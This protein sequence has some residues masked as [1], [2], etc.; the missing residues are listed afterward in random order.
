M[1]TP[2]IMKDQ[3]E[4]MNTIH[5]LADNRV[6]ACDENCRKKGKRNLV[7]LSLIFIM[8]FMAGY[9]INPITLRKVWLIA[10]GTLAVI[11]GLLLFLVQVRIVSLKC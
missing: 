8:L 11:A 4:N 9:F 10:S 3:L 1:K 2:E 5:D 6:S 7:L